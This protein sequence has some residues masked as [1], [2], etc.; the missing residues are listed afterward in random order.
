MDA[1]STLPPAGLLPDSLRIIVADDVQSI[2]LSVRHLLYKTHHILQQQW[3]IEC[4]IVIES[5]GTLRELR[6]RM[7]ASAVHGVVTDYHFPKNDPNDQ[8]IESGLIF[9]QDMR[10]DAS[11]AVQRSIPIILHSN[12]Y[13]GDFN[14]LRD[15]ITKHPHMWFQQKG[16][17]A[18][19]FQHLLYRFLE[20]SLAHS[21]ITSL[22][23]IK[24]Q[25]PYDGKHPPS[26]PDV[27]SWRLSDIEHL[28]Q[29][30][31][32]QGKMSN[33]LRIALVGR[34]SNRCLSLALRKVLDQ[35]HKV[36]KKEWGIGDDV[37]IEQ[38][39][40]LSQLEETMQTPVDGIVLGYHCPERSKMS[41]DGGRRFVERVRRDD[42]YAAYRRLPIVLYGMEKTSDHETWYRQLPQPHHTWC[43]HT[44]ESI[45][46]QHL[47]LYTFMEHAMV[48]RAMHQ[49]LYNP[50]GV[51]ME[52][53]KRP[54]DELEHARISLD[55]RLG[56]VGGG[57]LRHALASAEEIP[58]PY[59][60]C[61]KAP[62]ALLETEG[63]QRDTAG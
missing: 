24:E 3:G 52:P 46:A 43:C 49:W 61:A 58:S 34:H 16:A 10:G 48:H 25:A 26:A 21:L 20:K 4:P 54:V 30:A 12:T 33:P 37:H 7:Q 59:T 28:V 44:G 38:I 41:R 51:R 29:I 63:P 35:S 32:P 31:Q 39:R 17:P 6:E 45:Q 19:E 14:A 9:I 13:Q 22:P 40:T 36:L 53:Q 55:I 8:P 57:L 15:Q 23:A 62:T 56:Y 18:A 27:P 11:N 47:P 2:C 5:V 60:Q 42:H 1:S 50:E